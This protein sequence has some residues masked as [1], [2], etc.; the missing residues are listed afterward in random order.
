MRLS[1]GLIRDWPM[2][3]LKLFDSEQAVEDRRAAGGHD[4][5]NP[6]AVV[7][8]IHNLAG[9]RGAADN[10]AQVV[11]RLLDRHVGHAQSIREPRQFRGCRIGPSAPAPMEMKVGD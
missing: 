7:S 3:G 10:L 8:E 1:G 4:G 2:L 6:L 5:G 11:L 9:R